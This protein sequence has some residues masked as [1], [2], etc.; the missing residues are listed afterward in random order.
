MDTHT[1]EDEMEEQLDMKDFVNRAFFR[2]DPHFGIIV[3]ELD[4]VEYEVAP[5]GD[6]HVRIVDPVTAST[7]GR[8]T[9]LNGRFVPA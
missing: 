4:G 7:L 2:A 6:D 9:H 8:L 5:D 1:Q 3:A